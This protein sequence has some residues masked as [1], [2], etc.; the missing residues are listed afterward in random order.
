MIIITI[1]KW[2]SLP[3]LNYHHDYHITTWSS[4]RNHDHHQHRNDQG[5]VLKVI[6]YNIYF[7]GRF[8]QMVCQSTTW[9]ICSIIQRY[10]RGVFHKFCHETLPSGFL[11]LFNFDSEVYWELWGK[12]GFAHVFGLEN[13][14]SC[15][16]TGIHQQKNNRK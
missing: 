3:L 12:L 13:G 8:N 14:I 2:S 7:Q 6:G 11:N 16:G 1:I 9:R 10:T 5:G 4:S 15:T